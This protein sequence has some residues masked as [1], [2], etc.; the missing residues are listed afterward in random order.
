VT[1]A[2]LGI[3][4]VVWVFL[5]ILVMAAVFGLISKEAV[6]TA[7]NW[8]GY[9][10]AHPLPWSYLTNAV[11]QVGLFHLAGNM[12]CLWL[13]GSYVEERTGS[14]KY[15]L[16]VVLGSVAGCLG[17]SYF[18]SGSGGSEASSRPMI[19]ASAVVAAIFG[20]HLV[21]HP[22]REHRFFMFVVMFPVYMGP[23]KW[24][25]PALFYIPM[26]FLSQVIELMREGSG[27]QVAYGGHIGGFLAGLGFAAIVRFTP[28]TSRAVYRE[29][30]AEL[31]QARKAAEVDYTNFQLALAQG[32]TEAALSLVRRH[33]Q[34]LVA[35]PLSVAEKI[36]LASQLVTRSESFGA[37]KIYR[38]VIAGQAT[39]DERLDA[40]LKLAE[41][42]LVYE[43]DLEGSKRLLR[44]LYQGFREHPRIGEIKLLIERVKKAERDLFKRRP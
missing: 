40:S 18:L 17:H 29:Q 11:T 23:V 27:A 37:S 38:E 31:A 6:Q 41:V 13:F 21:F 30:E 26:W 16:L 20:A 19:G 3:N 9:V 43:H 28:K 24:S 36:Q 10:A 32:A 44:A 42:L 25:M 2:L 1:Y 14:G 22:M 15:L 35:L 12:L 5:R 8:L 4:A 39:E 34:G 7:V 33:E